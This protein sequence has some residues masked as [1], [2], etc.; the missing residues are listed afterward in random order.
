MM[1]SF[2]GVSVAG[3]L[4]LETLSTLTPTEGDMNSPDVTNR[5]PYIASPYS[6]SQ[7]VADECPLY[8]AVDLPLFWNGLL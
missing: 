6:D 8:Q 4:L 1:L 5:V 2:T 7:P 3:V